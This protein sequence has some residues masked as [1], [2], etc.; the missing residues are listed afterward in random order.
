[1]KNYIKL[2][3]IT[4]LA[5]IFTVS[6]HAQSALFAGKDQS[7]AIRIYN[8]Y[9]GTLSVA[10]NVAGSNF[11]VVANGQVNTA[12]AGLVFTNATELAKAFGS[13]TDAAN[14][15]YAI[16]DV[17]QCLP[18]D[19]IRNK[20][21]ASSNTVAAGGWI[22]INFDTTQCAFYQVSVPRGVMYAPGS[23]SAIVDPQRGAN[24][25]FNVTRIYGQPTGTGT[26]TVT[27]YV[28][29]NTVWQKVIASPT[30]VLGAT[31]T[32]DTIRSDAVD[33]D[34][35]TQIRVGP[36]DSLII[37]ATRATSTL[38]STGNIGAALETRGL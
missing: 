36:T 4:A 8:G 22:T 27:A 16:C 5:V 30:Y 31:A 24:I 3:T 23:A 19:T 15:A 12:I 38:P 33:L 6:A 28:N 35:S 7:P 21:V 17:S 13:I 10:C 25:G 29:T 20:M 37:R 26:V 1:M 9:T 18:T 2:I 32:G 14:R 11:A 34:A